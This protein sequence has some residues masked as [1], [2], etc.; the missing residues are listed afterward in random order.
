MTRH[1]E[2]KLILEKKL[3]DSIKKY[4]ILNAVIETIVN[5]ANI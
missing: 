2:L 4:K 3:N 5:C 1:E